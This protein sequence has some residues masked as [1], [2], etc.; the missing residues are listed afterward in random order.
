MCLRMK[1]SNGSS[2]KS[3]ALTCIVLG[4]EE[5]FHPIFFLIERV[6]SFRKSSGMFKKWMDSFKLSTF[7]WSPNLECAASPI[8]TYQSFLKLPV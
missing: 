8:Y 2:V 4:K 6:V 3:R 5:T 7:E 1:I